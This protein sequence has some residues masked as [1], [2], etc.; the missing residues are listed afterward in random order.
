MSAT[1]SR[2][3]NPPKVSR[4]QWA[5]TLHRRPT[6][7]DVIF[8]KL[9]DSLV[10]RYWYT[11]AHLGDSVLHVD[12]DELGDVAI[13]MARSVQILLSLNG[14]ATLAGRP[15]Q[16]SLWNQDAGQLDALIEQSTS[17]AMDTLINWLEIASSCLIKRRHPGLLMLRERFA[18]TLRDF[19]E[20]QCAPDSELYPCI[21]HPLGDPEEYFPDNKLFA[22]PAD[23]TGN[24]ALDAYRLLVLVHDADTPAV[25]K[26]KLLAFVTTHPLLAPEYVTFVVGSL[27][28]A[29]ASAAGTDQKIDQTKTL[30][31]LRDEFLFRPCRHGLNPVAMFLRQ[32]L[33]A[34]DRQKLR[35]ERWSSQAVYGLF[36]VRQVEGSVVVLEDLTSGRGADVDSSTL[37]SDA[38]HVGDIVRTRLL[39]WDEKWLFS[40]IQEVTSKIEEGATLPSP[41]P[42]NLRRAVDEDDPRILAA[43]QLVRVIY[44]R[45]VER[46]GSPVATFANLDECREKLADFHYFLQMELRL[47]DGRQFCDAWNEDVKQAFTSFMVDEFAAEVPD[48]AHPAVLFD[49]VHGMAFIGNFAPIVAALAATDLAP[50]YVDAV[51]Q[52]LVDPCGRAWVVECLLKDHPARMCQ[53]L[54]EVCGQD[55]FSAEN[56][57]PVLINRLRPGALT[58]PL[59]PVPFLMR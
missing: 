51:Q 4:A 10:R 23:S 57:F 42:L 39:P 29:A 8:H 41:H 5:K 56:D 22:D 13:H 36:V 49:P 33:L 16:P 31:Q 59:R 46:F 25:V 37:P 40:G 45:F 14:V 47:P 17:T 28:V 19:F 52:Y 2:T 11:Q 9:A 44:E 48:T 38:L 50:A 32:Q 20:V 1:S 3:S 34:S 26:A 43:R 27:S 21:A 54:A 58:P 24:P 55:T 6:R 15:A 18:H 30:I 12:A 35:L 7:W 53:L